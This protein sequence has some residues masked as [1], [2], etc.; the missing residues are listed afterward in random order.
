MRLS[1]DEDRQQRARRDRRD[2][3]AADRDHRRQRDGERE[4]AGEA[5]REARLTRIG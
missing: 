5:H 4:P 1:P 3:A 2:P